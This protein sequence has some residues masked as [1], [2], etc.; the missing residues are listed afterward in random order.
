[1][2]TSRFTVKLLG[3]AFIA[4]IG[5]FSNCSKDRVEPKDEEQLNE[6]NSMNDYYNTKKQDEQEFVIDTSGTE[7]I[8]GH[9]GT[10]IYPSKELLMYSTGDSVQWPYTV[11][12]IELYPVKDMVYYQ[13]PTVGGG[14]LLTSH[15]EVKIT[16]FKNGEELVLRPNRT[17][18]IEMPNASP[19]VGMKTYYGSQNSTF[20]DWVNNPTGVFASTSYGYATAMKKLG[21][22]SCAKDPG[23]TASTVNYTFTS[24]TD[25]LTNVSKFIYFS[26]SKAL[27]QVY[28]ETSGDLPVGENAKILLIGID[29]SNQL[30]NF[31]TEE[32]ISS[33]N[34]IEVTMTAISDADLTALLDSL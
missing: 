30:F 27:M 10:K 25:N 23:F 18:P 16:A 28:G 5:L 31:Y 20:V 8:V 33:S 22:L 32:V 3:V 14:N 4:S 21:W 19:E 6:Y 17:W 34:T 7:P 26:D 15:G 1:M 12:L 11:K 29:G 9:E 24:T 13:M 2:K